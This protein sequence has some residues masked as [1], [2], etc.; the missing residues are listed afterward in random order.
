MHLHCFVLHLHCIF[1]WEGISNDLST[2]VFWSSIKYSFVWLCFSSNVLNWDKLKKQ[3]IQEMY[4]DLILYLNSLLNLNMG[5]FMDYKCQVMLTSFCMC[6]S[7]HRWFWRWQ[8][9][10][11]LKGWKLQNVESSIFVRIY[12]LHNSFFNGR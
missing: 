2:G 5:H 3:V 4:F 9:F 12:V 7:V 1:S 10:P 11:M 6:L 8:W